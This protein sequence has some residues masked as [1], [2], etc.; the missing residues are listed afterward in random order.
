MANQ[1]F[2]GTSRRFGCR[3]TKSGTRKP[4]RDSVRRATPSIAEFLRHA[5]ALNAEAERQGLS[6]PDQLRE[7]KAAAVPAS[8]R[9][10]ARCHSTNMRRIR[11]GRR[12]ESKGSESAQWKEIVARE[13]KLG[14][15]YTAP[16]PVAS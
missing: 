2:S 11:T 4:I 12:Y 7:E 15:T 6:H 3:A 16:H 14:I 1:V 5:L 9:R 10:K 8:E 13:G